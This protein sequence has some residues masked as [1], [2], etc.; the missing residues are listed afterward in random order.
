MSIMLRKANDEIA[1]LTEL[2]A[3][4]DAEI[5][6][7]KEL[8]RA[9]SQAG[10]VA[11][12]L[13]RQME[14]KAAELEALEDQ[15]TIEIA[16]VHEQK[17]A[18]VERLSVRVDSLESGNKTLKKVIAALSDRRDKLDAEISRLAELV[19]EWQCASGLMGS[20]GDPGDVTPKDASDYWTKAEKDNDAEVRRLRAE[21]AELQ[22]V[23][24]GVEMGN[25][26]WKAARDAWRERAKLLHTRVTRAARFEIK[27]HPNTKRLRDLGEQP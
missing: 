16:S 12:E 18:E 9:V 5:A 21:V 22:V 1:L 15:F 26:G 2:L 27:E 20:A 8:T 23:V 6:R 7:L 11:R 3:K 10:T 14:D 24:A 19:E 17:N 4:R 13:R 25:A